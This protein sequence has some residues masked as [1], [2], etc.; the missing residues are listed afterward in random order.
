MQKNRLDQFLDALEKTLETTIGQEE[1]WPLNPAQITSYFGDSLAVAIY[2]KANQLVKNKVSPKDAAKYFPSP[3]S[4][5]NF[6]VNHAALGLKVAHN[7]GW[8]KTSIKE[9]ERFFNYLF[10]VLK[11]QSKSDIF[12]RDGR[13]II[14]NDEEINKI[15]PDSFVEVDE[16]S[17]KTFVKFKLALF[18]L[19]WTLFYDTF[20]T[21]GFIFHGSYKKNGKILIIYDYFNLKPTEI[22]SEAKNVPFERIRLYAIYK[23]IDWR[24]NYF[25]REDA[26]LDL[27]NNLTSFLV[28]IDGKV[29]GIEKTSDLTNN[30]FQI[31]SVQTEHVNNLRPLEQ[32]KKGAEISYFEFRKLF[33]KNWQPPKEIDEIIKKHGDKFIKQYADYEKGRDIKTIFDP[34][35]NMV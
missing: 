28:E 23:N 12:I 6:L 21:T 34:R 5:R 10:D 24:I 30:V 11:A 1:F 35:N 16:K 29:V 33:G 13:Q 3:L 17:K 4:I 31:T 8:H 26:N 9:R 15:P 19:V 7:L 25:G 27:K 20:A 2:K 32:V 18:S 22:W 14:L